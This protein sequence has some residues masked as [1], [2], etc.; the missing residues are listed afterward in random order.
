MT[1]RRVTDEQYGQLWRRLQEVARRVD[2]GTVSLEDT[3]VELQ[4]L[5]DSRYSCDVF[6]DYNFSLVNMIKMGKYDVVSND[7]TQESFPIIG[8]GRHQQRVVLILLHFDRSVSSDSVIVK[9]RQQGLRPARIEHLLA[10][11]VARPGLQKQFP[12]AALGSMWQD[13]AGD[14]YVPLLGWPMQG[15]NLLLSCFGSDWHPCYR[16]VALREL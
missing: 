9:M 6:I 1:R 16:F 14:R 2:E 3:M 10:L 13:P 5:I 7:I 4:C 15:R 11:G 8:E 12:I